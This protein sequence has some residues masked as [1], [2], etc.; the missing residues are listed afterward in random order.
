LYETL[1]SEYPTERIDNAVYADVVEVVARIFLEA[2]QFLYFKENF[3][4]LLCCHFVSWLADVR[5]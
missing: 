1:R 5:G 4:L 2:L 3:G